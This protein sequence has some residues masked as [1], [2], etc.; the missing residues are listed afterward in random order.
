LNVFQ[1][2]CHW[3]TYRTFMDTLCFC[4]G[5]FAHFQEV[6]GIDAFNLLVRQVSDGGMEP[7]RPSLYAHR[8]RRGGTG[9]RTGCCV[10]CRR[11]DPENNMPCN[12][13]SANNKRLQRARKI[14]E[15]RDLVQH[16][17]DVAGGIKIG[18][19]AI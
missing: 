1:P 14:H 6:I 17:N 11:R 2:G 12:G 13:I 7:V 16:L 19:I 18:I 10:R 15:R 8:F 4:N 9:I 5:I 3:F